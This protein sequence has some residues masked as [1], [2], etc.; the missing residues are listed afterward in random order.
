MS[1]G[2]LLMS[3]I[4]SLSCFSMAAGEWAEWRGPEMDGIAKGEKFDASSLGSAKVA[5]KADLGPGYS[6]VAVAGGKVYSLGNK[7]NNDVIYCFDEATGKTLWEYSYPCP[8]TG[9][10]PGTRA[11]PVLSGKSVF[12]LSREGDLVCVDADGGKLIWKKNVKDLGAGVPKWGFASSAVVR[13]GIV[14]V[15][16][17]S[18]GMAFDAKTGKDAWEN[19]GGTGGYASV[20]PFKSGGAEYAAVFGEK[21]LYVV[22][23]KK[24][25]VKASF[26][27]ETSYNVNSPDPMILDNGSSIFISSGYGR[28]C[29]M[30]SFKGGKLE[31]VWENKSL[32]SHFPSPVLVDGFIY[33]VDGQAGKGSL[34]CIDKS[35]NQ[36][37]KGNTG[38]GAFVVV[39]KTIIY[40]NEGGNLIA[41]KVSPD[42]YQEIS[43]FNTGIGKTCWNMPVFCNGRIYCRTEKGALA[44]VSVK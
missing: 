19:K 42:S 27:W 35:G 38:F 29:A 41:V 37:W 33:G 8:A 34:V 44:A 17:G 16:A 10:Y 6:I 40:L 28:G 25:S 22:D 2:K 7:N 36:K 43:K 4:L 13:N 1:I 30:L 9:N 21:S 26:P 31:K 32:S 3:A 18:N 5:W 15:N 11:T 24:G 20:V 14:M 12:A 39:D 23:M